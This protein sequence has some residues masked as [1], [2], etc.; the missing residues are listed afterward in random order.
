MIFNKFLKEDIEKMEGIEKGILFASKNGYQTEIKYSEKDG[1]YYGKIEGIDDLVDFEG[2]TYDSCLQA[3]YE[4]VED[5]EVFM[6]DLPRPTHF[7]SK[8]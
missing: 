1:C 4:A 8:T 6:N 7:V 2:D 3:F 5:Y